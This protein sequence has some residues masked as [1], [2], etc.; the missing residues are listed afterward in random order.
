MLQRIVISNVKEV[1][2]G[3][4][5]KKCEAE[6]LFGKKLSFRS[7]AVFQEIALQIAFVVFRIFIHTCVKS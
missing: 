2:H 3:E 5:T 1:N 7:L 6:L 4:D